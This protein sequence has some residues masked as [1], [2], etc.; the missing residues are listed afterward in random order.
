MSWKA[1]KK[2]VGEET[3]IL[4]LI[5]PS[6]YSVTFESRFGKELFFKND[7]VHLVFLNS[8]NSAS[9][10][11]SSSS[12]GS[13]S[14]SATISSVLA[15]AFEPL[16][17]RRRRNLRTMRLVVFYPANLVFGLPVLLPVSVI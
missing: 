3:L 5:V 17:L 16:T 10:S 13:S 6:V 12:A 7:S 4:G 2:K 8:A 14:T 9:K 11:S 15:A 1:D